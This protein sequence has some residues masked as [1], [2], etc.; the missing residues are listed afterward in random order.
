LLRLWVW[1]RSPRFAASRS[2]CQQRRRRHAEISAGRQGGSRQP[3]HRPGAGCAL[4]QGKFDDKS[5]KFGKAFDAP[6]GSK[7]WNPVKI[8]MMQGGK[9]T[10]GTVFAATDPSTYCAMAN[11]RLRLHLDR[12]SA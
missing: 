11:A 10:G 6:P 12:A 4:N 3:C 7:I 9:V 1:V 5:W 2:L 8:K